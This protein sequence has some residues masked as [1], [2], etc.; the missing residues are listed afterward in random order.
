V[1]QGRVEDRQARIDV[2]LHLPGGTRSV[3][4]EFVIDTGFEGALTMPS[5]AISALGLPFLQDMTAKL[6]ND[7]SV[8]TDVHIATI[9]WNGKLL[10]V[11]VLA[12]G[13]RP[14]LGTALLAGTEL[15]A[16][17]VHGGIVTIETL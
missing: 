10:D 6:A 2:A 1:S 3:A 12:L 9:E 15:V 14:L 4:I 8:R 16:Q 13:R 17:F 11:P 5:D 7:E